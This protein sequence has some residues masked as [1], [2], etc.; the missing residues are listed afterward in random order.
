MFDQSSRTV[1]WLAGLAVMS[2][3]IAALLP[4]VATGGHVASVTGFFAGLGVGM[5]V[6]MLRIRWRRSRAAG[7]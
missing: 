2:F 6:V 1:P 5:C 7:Q 3:L 4:R